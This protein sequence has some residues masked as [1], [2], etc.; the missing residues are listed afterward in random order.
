MTVT[1]PTRSLLTILALA[2][3]LALNAPD[4]EARRFGGGRSIG[5]SHSTSGPT[6]APHHETH[7]DTAPDIVYRPTSLPSLRYQ[8]PLP[9]SASNFRSNNYGSDTA[10]AVAR[11][12]TML[13]AESLAARRQ[14]AQA[15]SVSSDSGSADDAAR[16]LM[17]RNQA[18]PQPE[19]APRYERVADPR[20]ARITDNVAP[21][22]PCEFKP[23]ITD[24]DYIVCGATPPSYSAGR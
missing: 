16:F 8:A 3:T 21:S 9:P 20:F 11:T 6:H 7:H 15:G 18:T 19:P 10:Q 4:A 12:E 14:R 22:R 2:G 23:V 24:D 13:R 17:P 1:A 5:M